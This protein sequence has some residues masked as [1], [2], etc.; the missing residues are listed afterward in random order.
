MI[1]YS[2]G[3]TEALNLVARAPSIAKLVLLAPFFSFPT[4]DGYPPI[5]LYTLGELYF[6]TLPF[7]ISTV[8]SCH[9][10]ACG[11]AAR[12]LLRDEIERPVREETPM[13]CV[14]AEIDESCDASFS[15]KFFRDLL[16]ND[17]S[18]LSTV[19]FSHSL[20]RLRIQSDKLPFYH[21]F[22]KTCRWRQF[23]N[24]WPER[25]RFTQAERLGACY[26]FGPT[27]VQSHTFA[28]T[29]SWRR[30]VFS[31]NDYYRTD[32]SRADYG[33]TVY[34]RINYGR[35]GQAEAYAVC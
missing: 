26:Q 3:R 28:R 7:P 22:L 20:G 10:A 29:S 13:F 9:L 18:I 16:D 31:G 19:C 35:A 5:H 34:D 27:A 8:I 12:I 1:G 15:Q 24:G 11:F 6:Y 25:S 4:P 21:W 30:F 14:L 17:R 23:R 2:L 32:Y 33:R